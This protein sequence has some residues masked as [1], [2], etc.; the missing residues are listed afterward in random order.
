[1]FSIGRNYIEN[2]SQSEV[3]IGVRYS[4][5]D[6]DKKFTKVVKI[7]TYFALLMSFSEEFFIKSINMDPKR[8]IKVI[9]DNIG[10]FI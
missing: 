2:S 4:I 5:K 7:A 3:L 6:S 1:M 8:G 9:A 10:I